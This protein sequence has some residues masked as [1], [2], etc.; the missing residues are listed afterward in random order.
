MRSY[1]G[2]VWSET[3]RWLFSYNP[4]ADALCINYFQGLLIGARG[5]TVVSQSFYFGVE[6]GHHF[7]F[8]S[9]FVRGREAS[10]IIEFPYFRQKFPNGSVP[11]KSITDKF[12][13]CFPR[14]C[15]L[16]IKRNM[17]GKLLWC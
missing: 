12:L 7:L 8:G 10:A 14:S 4:S 5:K 11:E 17:H 2:F 3:V 1:S 13:R 9:P 16:D 6:F 15:R